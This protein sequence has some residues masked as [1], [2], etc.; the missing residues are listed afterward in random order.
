[1]KV[2]KRLC[3]ILSLSLGCSFAYARDLNQDEA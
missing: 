1:M 3:A 2:D